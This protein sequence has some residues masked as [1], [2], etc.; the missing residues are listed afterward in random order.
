[1][2]WEKRLRDKSIRRGSQWWKE[3]DENVI[4]NECIAKQ[5]KLII[6][7]VKCLV[8]ER[9]RVFVNSTSECPMLDQA[10][11]YRKKIRKLI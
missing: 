11:F 8:R 9:W 10:N 7:K 1:M 4:K 2:G 5:L 3:D 6:V